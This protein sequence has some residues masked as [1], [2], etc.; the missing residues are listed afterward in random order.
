MPTIHFTRSLSPKKNHL[1]HQVKIQ[2][3]IMKQKFGICPM[4]SFQKTVGTWNKN[5]TLG[6]D[7][8]NVFLIFLCF[9]SRAL[10]CGRLSDFFTT[11]NKTGRKTGKWWVLSFE[12]YSSFIQ[13]EE[14]EIMG[15]CFSNILKFQ[16]CWNSG[17]VICWLFGAALESNVGI[18]FF[19]LSGNMRSHQTDPSQPRKKWFSDDESSRANLNLA[20]NS[21]HP[22]CT[23]KCVSLLKSTLQSLPTAMPQ[24]PNRRMLL[25]LEVS[26]SWVRRSDFQDFK[27]WSG[28]TRGSEGYRDLPHLQND[29]SKRWSPFAWASAD[30]LIENWRR[31]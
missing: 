29:I 3:W 9:L 28:V 8:G 4:R 26:W 5:I 13:D 10:S 22:N 21:S 2:I 11:W 6:G 12:H 19:F 30:D 20:L 16:G 18:V 17:R 23:E 24:C 1:L 14:Q 31:L 25:L 15:L 7:D 27:C